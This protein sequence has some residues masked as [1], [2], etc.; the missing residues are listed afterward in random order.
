MMAAAREEINV[1]DVPRTP[2]FASRNKFFGL[3][4][5]DIA[6]A[7]MSPSKRMLEKPDLALD[8]VED[9]EGEGDI[10]ARLKRQVTLDR[11]SL[12]AL[13]MELDEERS[14]AAVAANNAMAMIT[15]LQQEKAAV[16][17]E[18]SQ[19]QR[20][21]EEQKEYDQEAMQMMQDLLFKREEETKELEAELELYREKYGMIKMIGSEVC[22]VDID[23]DYQ[24]IVHAQSLS[25]E[26]S[27]AENR[28]ES[29]DH[30]SEEFGLDYERERSH[31]LG[32]MRELLEGNG[33]EEESKNGG[34]SLIRER[35]KAVEEESGFLKHA[36][37]TM[38][39][40]GEGMKILSEIAQNLR[41]LRQKNL[42]PSS[43][44]SS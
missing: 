17:M 2:T 8:P 23:E 30:Q 12:M 32:L 28:S 29:V 25:L 43:S 10:V 5:A 27:S 4:F 22:E 16:Q 1:E 37:M 3:S 11:R 31:L 33:G 7:P 21:M 6:A 20:M 35:L 9:G 40:G 26:S 15:R 42:E 38:Q 44:S 41:V 18:A 24:D 36:A 39:R 19:Y 13:Y 34:V 14:A